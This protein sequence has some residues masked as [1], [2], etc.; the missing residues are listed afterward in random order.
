VFRRET[1]EAMLDE[2]FQA[3]RS[4]P[5]GDK[6]RLLRER[7]GFTAFQGNAGYEEWERGIGVKLA[8]EVAGA[9]G[10]GPPASQRKGIYSFDVR[11]TILGSPGQEDLKPV[12][13]FGYS[14]ASLLRYN[15]PGNQGI[16]LDVSGLEAAEVPTLLTVIKPGAPGAGTPTG[17][18]P[19]AGSGRGAGTSG[20]GGA[21]TKAAR[22]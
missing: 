19:T 7:A 1:A 16:V 11:E 5:G 18:R 22:P 12:E 21:G 10:G 14:L 9:P 17:V 20:A 6:L 3:V 2:V 4:E 15:Q 8:S 13:R